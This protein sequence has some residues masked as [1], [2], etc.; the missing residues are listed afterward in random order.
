MAFELSQY[1]DTVFILYVDPH[2]KDETVSQAPYHYNG[3]F[4]AFRDG[5]IFLNRALKSGLILGLC[6]ANERCRYKVM[7]SFI[8]W[9]QT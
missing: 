9:S 7:L 4:Y 1:K 8:G 5:L 6:P 3:N 2:F